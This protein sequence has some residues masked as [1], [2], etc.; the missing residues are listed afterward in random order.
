MNQKVLITG[1]V[2]KKWLGELKDIA[3]VTIWNGKGG[4]FI[5][6]KK[7]LLEIDSYDALLNFTDV[8]ADKELLQKAKKLKIIA[9]CAIGF[10]NLNI[11]LLTSHG[12]WASNAPGYFNF[13]VAEYVLA[14]MLVLSRRLLEAD[15]YVRKSQWKTFEPGRWDGFSLK[16]RTV[17][18]VGMG[19]TGKELRKLLKAL[20]ATVIYHT[21]S[22]KKEQGWVPFEELVS[23]ADIISIHIPLT[24]QTHSLFSSK[25]FAQIK[26]GAIIV[27]TSRGPIVDE[28]ALIEG[29]ESGRIGGAVLDVFKEEPKVPQKL[30]KMKNV[31]LTPHIAGGT[32]FSREASLKKA[33]GNIVDALKGNRPLNALNELPL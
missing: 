29:L 21:P 8:K 4:F 3:S 26:H 30:I 6:R 12:I 16:E 32:A 14:G 11:P 10:D 27:N 23:T 20:G 25:V 24:S 15:D 17:G 2:P 28:A 9:N 31:L 18:I 1:K 13:P 5:P 7:L 33:V 19:A 22:P